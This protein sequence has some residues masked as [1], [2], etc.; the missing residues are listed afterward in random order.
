MNINHEPPGSTANRNNPHA[1]ALPPVRFK[2]QELLEFGE[3]PVMIWHLVSSI[4]T[5][6][7]KQPTT[8]DVKRTFTAID[9]ALD[10]VN[11]AE[12]KPDAFLLFNPST[13]SYHQHRFDPDD[14]FDISQY[15]SASIPT[16]P[17]S[18]FEISFAIMAPYRQYW[19]SL[20]PFPSIQSACTNA[21]GKCFPDNFH[22]KA[23]VFLG[24]ITEVP[25]NLL[26][27]KK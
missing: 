20:L 1:S 16:R 14:Y 5:P 22:G 25:T 9:R 24:I 26:P 27:Q 11:S 12:G 17:V 23:N 10:L 19:D 15:S 21:N 13:N 2:H 3:T 4:T 18:R 6:K 7:P 8:E